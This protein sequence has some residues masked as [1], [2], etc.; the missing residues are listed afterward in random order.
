[1]DLGLKETEQITCSPQRKEWIQDPEIN[2]YIYFQETL[3]EQKD[4]S[5][6]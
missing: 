1:M 3:P 6:P 4:S 5:D 2:N